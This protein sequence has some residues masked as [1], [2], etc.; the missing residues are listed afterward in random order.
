MQPNKNTKL[1]TG[2]VPLGNNKDCKYYVYNN[3]YLKGLYEIYCLCK[4]AY[5]DKNC[6][7]PILKCIK[8]DN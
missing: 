2:S 1:F 6:K 5:Y 8:L 4:L 3:Y 7:E